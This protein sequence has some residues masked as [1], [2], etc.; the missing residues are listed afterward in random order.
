M[1]HNADKLTPAE[2]KGLRT[3]KKLEGHLVSESPIRLTPRILV[4]P[5]L[6]SRAAVIAYGGTLRRDQAA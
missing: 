6:R 4:V 1:T 5:P 2:A 3:A